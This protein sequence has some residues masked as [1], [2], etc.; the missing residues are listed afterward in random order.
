VRQRHF[1]SGRAKPTAC[2]QAASLGPRRVGC[3]S[4]PRRG[5]R[6][7]RA[8]S[9][10]V[11]PLQSRLLLLVPVS[12]E[13]MAT[14]QMGHSTG[15]AGHPPPSSTGVQGMQFLRAHS[16]QAA[17]GEPVHRGPGSCCSPNAASARSYPGSPTELTCASCPAAAGER[18]GPSVRHAP[19]APRCSL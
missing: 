19:S 3:E 6:A 14:T 5:S 9:E 1:P 12:A 17:D 7:E 10:P 11:P 18:E 4:P 8:Y 13:Q 2:R 15:L 16:L